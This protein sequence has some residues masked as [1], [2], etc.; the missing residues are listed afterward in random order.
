MLSVPQ[1]QNKDNH[2]KTAPIPCMIYYLVFEETNS[3]RLRIILKKHYVP[4]FT[5]INI[6]L[7]HVFIYSPLLIRAKMGRGDKIS[8]L[9]FAAL[10]TVSLVIAEDSSAQDSIA[11]STPTQTDNHA[12]IIIKVNNATITNY[13]NVINSTEKIVEDDLS[14]NSTSTNATNPA[15]NS[16][17]IN[18][19]SLTPVEKSETTNDYQN[20]NTNDSTQAMEITR[21]NVTLYYN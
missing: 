11:D 7:L 21:E 2:R 19:T 3:N 6:S 5:W 4:Y 8:S 15:F 12:A 10:L 16:T 14:S 18:S 17:L 13:G 20:A 9:V 1:P